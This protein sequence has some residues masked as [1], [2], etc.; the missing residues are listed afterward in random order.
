MALIAQYRPRFSHGTSIGT[1]ALFPSAVHN[2]CKQMIARNTLSMN[3]CFT[4]AS[5][6][7]VESCLY[8]AE[9]AREFPISVLTQEV[10]YCRSVLF[11]LHEALHVLSCHVMCIC[12]C[13][14][15]MDILGICWWWFYLYLSIYLWLVCYEL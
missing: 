2:V 10:M 8:K 1:K 12:V 14:F 3:V 6:T 7:V 13:V 15:C 5:Y 9:Q 4:Y 11:K